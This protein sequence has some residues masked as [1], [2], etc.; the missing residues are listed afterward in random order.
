[1]C[2]SGVQGGLVVALLSPALPVRA[3][4]LYNYCKSRMSATY[5][6]TQKAPDE[7]ISSIPV[8]QTVIHGKCLIMQ[9]ITGHKVTPL[10]CMITGVMSDFT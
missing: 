5:L 7:I 6:R 8:I 1:M 3:S 10:W 2:S 9:D 4:F